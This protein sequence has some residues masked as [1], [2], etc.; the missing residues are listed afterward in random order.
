[1]LINQ[2]YDG[3]AIL[4]M[5][6]LGSDIIALEAPLGKA[7][8]LGVEEGPHGPRFVPFRT[9]PRPCVA[10]PSIAPSTS[11]ASTPGHVNPLASAASTR[12]NDDGG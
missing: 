1:V 4:V 6:H 2:G 11:A 5:K 8:K 3:N 12:Q 7:A 9:G 10:A